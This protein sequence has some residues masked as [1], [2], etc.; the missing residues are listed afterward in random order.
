MGNK[1][2]ARLTAPSTAD[3]YWR[4]TSCGGKNECIYISSGSVLP[5]CVG[6]AW[7]R[8]YELMGERPK[9]SKSNAENWYANTADGYKR[10]Q[11]PS[12][13]AVACWRKGQAFNETDGCG[14]VA[15]VEEIKPNG[16]IVVSQSAY[17]GSRFYVST[18]AKADSYCKGALKFQ[19]FILPPL[20]F[21]HSS[22]NPSNPD[23]KSLDTLAKEIWMGKWGAGKDREKRIIA[24]GYDYDAV[25]RRV[26]ETYYG[27]KFKPYS[28][29]V[30]YSDLRIREGAGTNYNSKG[31]IKPG[32]YKIA[33]EENG[34]G[35][36]LWGKLADGRGWI[37]LD[38][39]NRRQR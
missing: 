34:Q 3:P 33:A 24:A 27:A 23:V 28:V 35:A 29:R 7:G 17:G 2:N 18:Y 13:G 11:T 39:T 12:L 20:T 22:T 30:S 6:Y 32:V 19:G 9:L 31:Y 10:S 21:D 14:H 1:F 26:N 38:Y 8:F 15:I 5:N 25:Q 16:D 36:K 4:H 37:A